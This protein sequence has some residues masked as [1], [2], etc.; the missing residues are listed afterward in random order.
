M[1]QWAKTNKYI[2]WYMVCFLALGWIDQR[3]GSAL[4]QIQMT[5]ANLTGV[6]IAFMLLPGM[7]LSKFRE[8]V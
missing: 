3:R 2:L 6:V 7:D 1:K 4:G 5:F 8:K